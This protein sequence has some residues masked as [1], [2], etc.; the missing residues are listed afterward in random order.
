MSHFVIEEGGLI[1]VGLVLFVLMSVRPTPVACFPRMKF[2]EDHGFR[3]TFRES[4]RRW[5]TG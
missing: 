2:M 4:M 3:D 5:D 1:F